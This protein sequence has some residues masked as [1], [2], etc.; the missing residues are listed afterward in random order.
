MSHFY[1]Y[2][3]LQYILTMNVDNITVPCSPDELSFFFNE[4]SMLHIMCTP[5]P[6]KDLKGYIPVA[7]A[8]YTLLAKL[9]REDKENV[10]CEITN[11]GPLVL[12]SYSERTFS[13][14]SIV[15]SFYQ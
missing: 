2:L 6:V 10:C 15:V 12:P 5:L 11:L 3:L 1:N 7:K 14:W 13:V 9:T 8:G 4:H